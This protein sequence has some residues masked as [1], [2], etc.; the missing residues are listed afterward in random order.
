M[1]TLNLTL[2]S[3]FKVKSFFYVNVDF[4]SGFWKRASIFIGIK[5]YFKVIFYVLNVHAD[6]KLNTVILFQ[7]LKVENDRTHKR[8]PK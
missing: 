5:G 8:V 2:K 6:I 1:M 3:T 4:Y 7:E